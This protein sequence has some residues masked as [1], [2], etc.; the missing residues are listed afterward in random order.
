MKVMIIG[1]NGLLG[2]SLKEV[3]KNEHEVVALDNPEIDISNKASVFNIVE[4]H[5]PDVIIN[6]AAI[7]AVDLIENDEKM[8]KL[9]MSVNAEG[10]GIVAAAAKKN[11]AIVVHFSS[12]Y[13][14]KGDNKDG[15]IEDDAVDPVNKYGITK[16]EGEK[17][18]MENTDRYYLIR[19][20]RLFGEPASAPGAKKSFVEKIIE[21]SVVEKEL[22]VVDDEFSSPTYSND[23]ADLVKMLLDKKMEF[24]IYHGANSGACSWYEFAGE[25]FR[26]KDIKTALMPQKSLMNDAK[27][28]P[29]PKYS[30][31]LNTKLPKQRPWQ[32]AL[33]EYLN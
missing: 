23:L 12:D 4:H 5:R 15:Y 14:F 28:A 2:T 8:L 6:S 17:K 10:V 25:I 32:E 27:M 30:E 13:V 24:G 18:L 21:K 22:S 7:N 11:N 19:L 16:A 29:R 26:I 33:A 1:S 20:S 9:A 3:F 31:L